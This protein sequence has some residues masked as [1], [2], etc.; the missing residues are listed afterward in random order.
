[1]QTL[2]EDNL[3]VQLQPDARVGLEAQV[4][5]GAAAAQKGAVGGPQVCDHDLVPV[6]LHVCK[7]VLRR[8]GA[9]WVVEAADGFSPTVICAWML[10]TVGMLMMIWQGSLRPISY[11]PVGSSYSGG[12]RMTLFLSAGRC[13]AE[14]T[15]QGTCL[16]GCTALLSRHNSRALGALQAMQMHSVQVSDR[17]KDQL[18]CNLEPSGPPGSRSS[19]MPSTSMQ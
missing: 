17:P 13:T 11:V 19:T 10:E 14:H 12:L 6:A 2:T 5:A 8:Q 4:V 9:T 15:S 7:G 18:G 16:T 1:M 3:L